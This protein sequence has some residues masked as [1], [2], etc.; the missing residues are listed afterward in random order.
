L[1]TEEAGGETHREPVTDPA[2]SLAD[3][4]DARIAELE[5]YYQESQASWER[6]RPLE[7]ELRPL[8]EDEGFRGFMR[9]ARE[10]YYDQKKKREAEAKPQLDPG[11]Q[12]LLEAFKPTLDF[13]ESLRGEREQSKKQAEAEAKK[14][15]ED[16]TRDNV[17]Y[18]QRLMAEQGL[19]AEEI[20]D[21]GRFA[22]AMHDE[23]VARGE[24]RFVPLEEAY[25]RTYGRAS[26]QAAKKPVP[27]SLR[28]KA[29]AP[30]IPGPSS[31]PEE[32]RK[33]NPARSGDFTQEMLRRMNA[34]KTG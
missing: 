34:R 17:A 24:P 19:S 20:L 6:L 9:S 23:T 11:G 14:A 16:F 26:A 15:S 2:P 10:S 3:P 25:K 21:L 18:A 22:K 28:S 12:A 13:V 8:V 1:A 4:R 5:R 29:A 33:I 7:D 31:A 30:G 32:K 27:A